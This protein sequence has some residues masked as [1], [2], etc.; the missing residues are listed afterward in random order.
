M[1]VC[2]LREKSLGERGLKQNGCVGKTSVCG[3]AR[4]SCRSR[5]SRAEKQLSYSS[6]SYRGY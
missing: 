6:G 2:S 4:P 1:K 5:E 3:S